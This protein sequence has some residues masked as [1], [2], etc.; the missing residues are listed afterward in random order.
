MSDQNFEKMK[1]VFL[2]KLSANLGLN[3][4]EVDESRDEKY[5]ARLGWLI[6]IFG[7]GTFM[8]WATFAPLDKGASAS[9][10][11]IVS[12]QRKTIQSAN[13]GV[14]DSILVKDGDHVEA[15]QVL[16]KLNDLQTSAMTVGARENI[17]GLEAQVKGLE[18]STE[19]QKLQLKYLKE[20]IAGMRDLV[21]EGYV[22]KNRL[23][24]LER[25]N[26]QVAGNLAEN[27]GNLERYRRQLAELKSKLNAFEFDLQNAEIKAPVAGSVLNLEVFTKG[28]VVQAGAKLL[29]I[30]PDNQPLM[31]E[32]MV[33]VTLIDKVHLELPVQIMFPAL[34]QRSTPNIPGKVVMVSADRSIDKQTGAPYYKIQAEVT[35]KG[36]K[37][38]RQNVIRAGMPA[39]VF[40]VTGERTMMNYLLRPILDRAHTSMR[41]E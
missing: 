5:Y 16:I 10:T 24:E 3:N 22:A 35:E 36:M 1:A 13:N 30:A 27:Q 6:L 25:T 7:F 18:I 14:I 29:E 40:I 34:N 8:V 41:E 11:V 32:A 15:G 33:P 21:A 12:G 9:G 39:E 38:L 37:L 17:V 26:A 28:A 2:E 31:I 23:L 19:N 4:T 20:Q